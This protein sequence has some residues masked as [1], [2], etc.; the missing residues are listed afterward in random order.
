MQGVC[1]SFYT[2][3]MT[4]K[5]SAESETTMTELVL[6]QHTNEHGTIFGGV[7]MSWID[8]AAAIAAKRHSGRVCVTAAID[9]LH[10]LRPVRQGDI[11]NIRA[12][13]TTSGR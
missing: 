11:V 2:S 3:S 10:F 8:I 9:E 12:R 5:T 1:V 4:G 7:I 6:P 13:L